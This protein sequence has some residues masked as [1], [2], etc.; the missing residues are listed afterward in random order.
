MQSRLRE[1]SRAIAERTFQGFNYYTVG[2]DCTLP[3]SWYGCR[4][5]ELEDRG[6]QKSGRDAAPATLRND[7]NGCSKTGWQ[8]EGCCCAEHE[9]Y[10]RHTARA[11]GHK[12][13]HRYTWNGSQAV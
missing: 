7:D 2:N 1:I 12:D 6:R 8:L 3:T 11:K 4:S 13:P 9:C 5:L 10:A